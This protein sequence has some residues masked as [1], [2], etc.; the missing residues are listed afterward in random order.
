MSGFKYEAIDSD[1]RSRTG[2]IEADTPRQVRSNL[3]EQGLIAV[4]VD[5]LS[6]KSVSGGWR[7]SLRRGLPLSE[8][9]LLTRQ[10]A[11][12]L[13]AGLPIDQTLNA[14]IEQSESQHL[15]QILAGVRSEVLAGH[16]LAR[17]LSKYPSVFPELY[18]TLVQSGE[19][20]GQLSKVL[21]RLAD[22]MEDRHALR[23]KVALAFIYPA[24][25][26]LVAVAVVIGLLTYVVPQVVNVF[27]N[28]HQQLPL[29]TRAL[30]G[31]SSFLRSTWFIWLAALAAGAW[32]ARRALKHEPVRYRFHLWLLGLPLIGRLI[33][34]I[35][36]ARLASTLAILVGSGVPLLT[37]LQAGA[38]VLGNLPMRKALEETVRMVREGGSFSRSL[39]HGKMFPPVMIHLIASGEASGTL[40]QMLER[41]AVQQ[42]QEMQ[43]R[44]ATLTGLLEPLLILLMGGVV[45][46]IV[47]A[48][49][50]PIFEMNQLVH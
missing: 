2:V 40:D 5:A 10:M 21:L 50:L 17:A 37:A 18:Q 13:N 12:L 45:L 34:G 49:L 7:W 41:I 42:S 31:L 26:T 20:S 27:Q 16:A 22:Y 38:G 15:R 44:V 23:Q 28:T 24:M 14:L 36:T 43:T 1:G 8:L 29:L 6:E 3:R 9:S 32:G 4:R 30:I 33:R 39:A 11:T 19:Q 48:I 46:V 47:L 25:V 35:N